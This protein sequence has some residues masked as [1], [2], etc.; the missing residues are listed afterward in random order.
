MFLVN[1]FVLIM[2]ILFSLTRWNCWV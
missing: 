1:F 2:V